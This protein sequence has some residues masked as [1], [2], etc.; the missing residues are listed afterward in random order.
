MTINVLLQCIVLRHICLFSTRPLCMHG[1]LYDILSDSL[2]RAVIMPKR[3]NMS[4][5]TLHAGIPVLKLHNSD[6]FK[7]EKERH[8]V[9]PNFIL[10]CKFVA[11]IE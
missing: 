5:I 9:V 6:G 10:I 2:S 11:T 3:L 1:L 7:N 8:L 4:C